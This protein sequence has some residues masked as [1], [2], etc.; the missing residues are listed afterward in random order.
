MDDIESLIELPR[1]EVA[2]LLQIAETEASFQIFQQQ[3]DIN[4]FLE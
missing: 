2:Y 4:K 3:V 1:R